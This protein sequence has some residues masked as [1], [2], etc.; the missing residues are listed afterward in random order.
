MIGGALSLSLIELFVCDVLAEFPDESNTASSK[1][2]NTRVSLP[3]GTPS[4]FN[5]KL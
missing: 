3:S 2:E 4:N 5:F 1:G